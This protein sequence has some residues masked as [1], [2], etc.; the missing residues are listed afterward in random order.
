MH[1]DLAS[2]PAVESIDGLLANLEQSLADSLIARTNASTRIPLLQTRIGAARSSDLA[3]IC[4]KRAYLSL[5]SERL[6]N[7]MTRLLVS[8]H[9]FAVE[10]LR[11]T[12]PSVPRERRI[13]RFCKR[14]WAIEDECHLL[15]EC[16]GVDISALRETF[17]TD[18]SAVLPQLRRIAH[19]LPN[20][21]AVLDMLL[22]RE[23]TLQILAHFV[24]SVFELCNETPCLIIRNDDALLALDL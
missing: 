23:K 21:A 24:A 4:T 8:D 12:T 18:A 17:W 5:Q 7:A 16:E 3:D 13:R 10:T 6:R 15:L 22:T 1:L 19:A 9:P 2:F 14:R 20:N 11:R